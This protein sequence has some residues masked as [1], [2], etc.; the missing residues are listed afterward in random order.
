VTAVAHASPAQLRRLAVVPAG[1][2]H[3]SASTAGVYR[4]RRIGA[5]V[6]VTS[7]VIALVIGVHGLLASFGGGPLTASERPG[8]AAAVYVVQPGDTFWSIATRLRP[9]DDP[10]PLVAE[11]VAAHGS[12]T[13]Q[14]GERLRLPHRA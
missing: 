3:R 5:A 9:G 13:L 10:R 6:V 2:P 11:L 7:L 4:R 8:D 14:A 1:S 12:P